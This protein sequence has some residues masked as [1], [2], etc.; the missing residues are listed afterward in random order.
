MDDYLANPDVLTN[1]WKFQHET[2]DNWW[3]MGCEHDN[4]TRGNPHL[5]RWSEEIKLGQNS[6]GSPSVLLF[7]NM[8]DKNDLFDENLSWVLDA[9]LYQRLFQRYGL[10]VIIDDINVVIG[11]H[12]G[13]TT[14]KLSDS[15]KQS[16]FEYL[17]KKYA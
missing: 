4:G 10:P 15:F 8:F 5:A 12:D 16:E 6:I 3:V 14:N 11:I 9:D 13:Q 7:R 1:L 2:Q 17:R